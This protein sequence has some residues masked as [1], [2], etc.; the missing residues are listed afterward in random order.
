MVYTACI[1]G[2]LLIVTL[3][4]IIITRIR[5]QNK[6][7]ITGQE[8]HD[9]RQHQNVEIIHRADSEDNSIAL[10]EYDYD[11][12]DENELQYSKEIYTRHIQINQESF[13]EDSSDE[14]A[15]EIVRND[16]YQNPYQP[17]IED[18][19]MHDYKTTYLTSRLPESINLDIELEPADTLS[20]N[21]LGGN[22]YFKIL[23]FNVPSKSVRYNRNKS[24]IQQHSSELKYHL[25]NGTSNGI[26]VGK[27]MIE[28]NSSIVKTTN[29]D[30][31]VAVY[32]SSSVQFD[33]SLSI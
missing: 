2:I 19:D 32:K 8:D 11:E 31:N 6:R 24:L 10:D 33:K 5:N 15:E 12:I 16:G 22:K 1:V 4:Y 20:S 18:L 30:R 25:A 9:N 17:I 21:S 14:D 29:M 28:L 26:K 23:D 13:S 27:S 7:N 3:C